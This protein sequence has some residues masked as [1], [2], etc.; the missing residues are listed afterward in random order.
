MEIWSEAL[1][2]ENV[3]VTDNF[4]DLGGDSLMLFWVHTHLQDV[5][6]IDIPIIILFKYPTIAALARFIIHRK[7]L[8]EGKPPADATAPDA[9]RPNRPA[10]PKHAAGSEESPVRDDIAIIGMAGTFPDAANTDEFWENIKNGVSS[11]RHYSTQELIDAGVDENLLGDPDYVKAGTYLEDIE[12]FDAA[13]LAS[14]PWK[15]PFSIRSTGCFW[16]P[17]GTPLNMRD[18]FRMISGA[19]WEFLPAPVPVLICR[20]ILCR[21]DTCCPS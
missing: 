13:F 18:I 17:P 9:F 8:M 21:K 15:R 16:K 14:G 6:D 20:S 4:F 19:G 10:E 3:G 12:K 2:L 5:F 7:G 11:V 1:G